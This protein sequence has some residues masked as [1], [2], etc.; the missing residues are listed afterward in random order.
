MGRPDL[1]IRWA[2]ENP[3][4]ALGIFPGKGSLQPGADADLVLV[5][6]NGVT[7][8]TPGSMLSRQRHS[9]FEGR[10]FGFALR[11]VYV[12]G[13]PVGRQPGRLVRPVLP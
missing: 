5:D 12:R 10:R 9:V 2:S 11:A 6:P 7:E 4:R 13:M 3:A 1:A 8:A